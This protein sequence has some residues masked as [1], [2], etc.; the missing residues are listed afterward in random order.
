[1]T[2]STKIKTPMMELPLLKGLEK[3]KADIIS[4]KLYRLQL[5]E[6]L[7]HENGITVTDL[8]KP[9]SSSINAQWVREYHIRLQLAPLQAIKKKYNITIKEVNDFFIIIFVFI[10]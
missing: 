10:L 2:A 5:T 1:M 7:H 4:Q 6:L 3:E 8:L 9:A